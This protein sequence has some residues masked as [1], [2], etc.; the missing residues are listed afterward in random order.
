MKDFAT[1]VD[2]ITLVIVNTTIWSDTAD[3]A[4]EQI[5]KYSAMILRAP[6]WKLINI[7]K[8]LWGLIE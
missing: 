2:V 7:V 3:M 6:G 4:G 8:R 1:K 5:A